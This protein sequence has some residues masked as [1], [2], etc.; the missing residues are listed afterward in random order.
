MLIL[1]VYKNALLWRPEVASGLRGGVHIG[2]VAQ[3]A[4]RPNIL[5]KLGSSGEDMSHQGPVGLRDAEIIV[6]ARGDTDQAAGV[7]GEAVRETLQGW[8]GN[9][10]GLWVQLTEL[11][12]EE[13]NYDD[14][15]KVFE[16][17]STYTSYFRKVA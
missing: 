3:G 4:L 10:N 5:L 9:A 16:H 7:L 6:T 12:S 15:A 17:I 1:T 2:Q 11:M 13:S 8:T 14:S